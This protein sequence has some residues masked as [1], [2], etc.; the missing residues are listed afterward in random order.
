M[1]DP[2]CSVPWLSPESPTRSHLAVI[3]L[4][5]YL[6]YHL[7]PQRGGWGG[8]PGKWIAPAAL[9]PDPTWLG[10]AVPMWEDLGAQKMV[11]S[12]QFLQAQFSED[13]ATKEVRG[14]PGQG[15]HQLVRGGGGE[16]CCSVVR[17]PAFVSALGLRSGLSE[18]GLIPSVIGL[19]FP[20][21]QDPCPLS[22][23]P[24]SGTASA[25]CKLGCAA[26]S[27]VS[28]AESVCV[29]LHQGPRPA[30]L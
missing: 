5:A 2:P 19:V 3:G 16:N 1:T 9:S 22:H 26:G 4:D 13:V 11:A 25:P 23:S 10:W 15:S 18:L 12:V 7:Q 29:C 28:R 6:W 17:C 24:G 20:R 30:P 27:L 21:G 8:I 14:S